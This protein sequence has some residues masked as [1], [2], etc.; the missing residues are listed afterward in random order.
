MWLWLFQSRFGKQLITPGSST[1]F[2]MPQGTL[3]RMFPFNDEQKEK[4]CLKGHCEGSGDAALY[5][6]ILM[7]EGNKGCLLKF[8]RAAIDDSLKKGKA[9]TCA[10]VL[11]A[12]ELGLPSN[13]IILMGT[14]YRV[15][16]GRE[17]K[18]KVAWNESLREGNKTTKWAV[19]PQLYCTYTDF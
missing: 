18:N 2:W 8:C 11:W 14:E 1:G 7:T 15:Q 6:L 5:S 17:F 12:H 10:R 4:G 16:S 3:N 13:P 9:C 19:L